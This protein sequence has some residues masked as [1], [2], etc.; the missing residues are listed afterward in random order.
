MEPDHDPQ[1]LQLPWRFRARVTRRTIWAGIRR[2]RTWTTLALALAVLAAVLASYQAGPGA[3]RTRAAGRSDVRRAI[4][5]G[6][7]EVA[8]YAEL[9]PPDRDQVV[10]R[11]EHRVFEE[12]PSPDC[13]PGPLPG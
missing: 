7:D 9:N 5:A 11:V 3:C 12:L 8:S 6:V 10:G 2:G 4:I 1:P 13:W